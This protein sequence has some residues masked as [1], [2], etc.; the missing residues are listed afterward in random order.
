MGI[1]NDLRKE[2][3][4]WTDHSFIHAIIENKHKKKIFKHLDLIDDVKEYP[5]VDYVYVNS[6]R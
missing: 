3:V 5:I 2:T 6:L 1:S 4:L